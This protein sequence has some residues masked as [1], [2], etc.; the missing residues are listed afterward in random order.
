M[1]YKIYHHFF[2]LPNLFIEVFLKFL[3]DRLYFFYSVILTLRKYCTDRKMTC[4]GLLLVYHL[5]ITLINLPE[6]SY[7]KFPE[8]IFHFSKLYITK[9]LM[10]LCVYIKILKVYFCEICH[11]F[12]LCNRMLY[13]KSS[14]IDIEHYLM[15]LQDLVHH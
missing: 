7:W 12:S 4:S 1:I 8:Q 14:A 9:I 15:I 3:I 13:I 2:P 5:F 11:C 10:F 6:A